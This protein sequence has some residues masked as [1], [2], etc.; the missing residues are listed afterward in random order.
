[1]LRKMMSIDTDLHLF[2]RETRTI[3]VVTWQP[4][5]LEAAQCFA[6][7]QGTELWHAVYVDNVPATQGMWCVCVVSQ[8]PFTAK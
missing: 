1:M 2:S 7:Y 3:E 8:L 6:L 5:K 4:D